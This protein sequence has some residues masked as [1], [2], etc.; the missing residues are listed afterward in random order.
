MPIPRRQIPISLEPATP[1]PLTAE[2]LQ[3]QLANIGL[4]CRDAHQDRLR[5]YIV[6]VK[7]QIPHGR[8]QSYA[9]LTPVPGL[10][11][12]TGQLTYRELAVAVQETGRASR[13]AKTL[14]DSSVGNWE[15]DPTGDGYG[16]ELEYI[17]FEA[18]FDWLKGNRTSF[19]GV[20]DNPP[21]YSGKYGS[22][23]AIKSL[24]I[25]VGTTAS[26]TLVNGLDRDSIESVLSNAIAPLSDA[27]A[28]NY[29]VSDSRVIFLVENYDPATKLADGIGVLTVWW[30]LTIHDYKKKSK[31]STQHDTNL[32]IKARSVLYSTLDAMYGDYN[33]AKAQF[34]G[35]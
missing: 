23:D 11:R 6:D 22:V 33:A 18:H 31:D 16:P 3:K 1:T 27:S 20:I 9:I 10:D 35:S 12:R 28:S 15:P 34:G 13:L 8:T 4:S 19:T 30:H 26:A 5:E 2:S 25:E 17:Q 24:F 29:D 14:G 32:T 21:A 7:A